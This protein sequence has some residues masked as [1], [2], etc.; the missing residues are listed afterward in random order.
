[1]GLGNLLEDIFKNVPDYKHFMT[2]DELNESSKSLAEEYKEVVQLKEI[3]K[4]RDGK[5]IFSL[6]IGN[7]GLN[8][9]LFAFPHP[10]EP[11]GSMMLEY[12]S[13]VY[14]Q[15]EELRKN[16]GF[17][18]HIVKVS[19]PDGA[20]LNEN[21][22]KG[23]FTP[24]NYALNYY[25]PAGNQQVE[26]T[27]PIKYKNLNFNKPI[28][29]TKALMKLIDETKP[30]FIY[31][32]HNAGFGGVYYYLSHDIP[33]LYPIYQYIALKQE[34]PLSLG[35]PEMPYA[36]KFADAVYSLPSTKERYDYLEKHSEKDPAEIIKSGTSSVD[37]AKRVNPNVCEL[38]CEVPYYYDPRINN[39]SESDVIRKD[40]ILSKLDF[41]ED[42]YKFLY[43]RFKGIHNLLTRPS[44]FKES[45]EYFLEVG[46]ESIKAERN[47]AKNN[48]ELERPAT[49]AEKFDNELVSKFYSML[50]TGLF[51]RMI[52]YQLELGFD[53]R[54]SDLA[55]KVKERLSELDEIVERE[56]NY[57]VIPIKKLVTVQLAAGL[58]TML[59]VKEIRRKYQS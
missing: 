39:L 23:P 44:R 20:K 34:L 21:W 48:P 53:K 10:N 32:L 41:R 1:M 26:W 11:V 49:V 18:L 7:G 52:T 27:F 15:N 43:D 42:L 33:L 56:M 47:W 37:Y 22:F 5:P 59:Y 9:V 55:E 51:L 16:M 31:S 28:P 29:E 2:V 6:K 14:A 4:S 25:R 19:D 45:I 36:I 13:N 58:Y 50:I 8:A 46:L 3:G 17:T 38:V 35:E 30:D 54:L 24:L 57:S 40:A 12:L